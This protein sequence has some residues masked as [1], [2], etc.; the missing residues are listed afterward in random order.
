MKEVQILFDY[1]KNIKE[2]TN[3]ENCLDFMYF[4]IFT[5]YRQKNK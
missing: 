4:L 5:L 3:N 2:I 1:L